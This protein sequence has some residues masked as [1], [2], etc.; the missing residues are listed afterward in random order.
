MENEE[1]KY[2][3]DLEDFTIKE[4]KEFQKNLENLN[5]KQWKETVKEF[6]KI[7]GLTDREAIAVAKY[8]LS[9]FNI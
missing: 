8:D 7:H 2:K 9:E 4:I 6:G 1:P 3:M 5:M